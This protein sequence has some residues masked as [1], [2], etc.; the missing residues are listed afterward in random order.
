MRR[1]SFALAISTAL[2]GVAVA[3]EG[4]VAQT[5]T[6]QFSDGSYITGDVSGR[7]RVYT[8]TPLGDGTYVTAPV[9]SP[10]LGY[11]GHDEQSSPRR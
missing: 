11:G 4:A 2:T 8:T 10:P 3:P 9:G 5:V 7:G 1:L 6:S